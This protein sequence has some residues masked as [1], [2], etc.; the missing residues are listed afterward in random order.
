M[1]TW[2]CPEMCFSGGETGG[3]GNSTQK[4]GMEPDLVALPPCVLPG[5]A[6]LPSSGLRIHAASGQ[7]VRL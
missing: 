2:V 1:R 5:Q 3:R 6:D 4:D 7:T